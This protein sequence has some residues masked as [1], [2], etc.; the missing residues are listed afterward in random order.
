MA[1]VK[2]DIQ[3]AACISK[4]ELKFLGQFL[5]KVGSVLGQR[6]GR[7]RSV[8]GLKMNF[9]WVLSSD[10]GKILFQSVLG[11]VGSVYSGS[12]LKGLSDAVG[13]GKL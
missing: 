9:G 5:D 6:F 13:S 8:L 11:C 7:V 1:S 4:P 3:Q 12:V 2:F 10:K